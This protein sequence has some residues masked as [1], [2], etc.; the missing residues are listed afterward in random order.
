LNPTRNEAPST[1]W[2]RRAITVPVLF[3]VALIYAVVFPAAGVLAALADAL[4]RR[5]AYLRAF[6]FLGVL[7]AAELVGVVLSAVLFVARLLPGHD[8][9]WFL[10]ANSRLQ[11]RWASSLLHAA[12]R[13]FSLR[14]E[15]SG[16]D[17][18]VPGPVVMLCRHASLG[19]T[20]IPATFVTA[21]H[22]LRLRYVLKRELLYDPCLDIV[23]QRLPNAFVAR[24][25]GD[26]QREIEKVRALA[27]D[28][29]EGEGILIY[30]EG[31]RFSETR[32][33]RVIAR[34]EERGDAEGAARARALTHVL[35]PELGGTLAVL[36]GL[37][38]ADVVVCAHTGFE[39]IRTLRELTDGSLVGRAVRVRFW[40]VRRGELPSDEA[41]LVEWLHATWREVD[42]WVAA[43]AEDAGGGAPA[44]P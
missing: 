14:V 41:G 42:A 13:L 20:V 44:G 6:C 31:T 38:E 7:L 16:D 36:T 12:A 33:Q 4:A 34:L 40:R 32:R 10:D 35:P 11:G 8:D 9:A 1:T 18:T 5:T 39:G 21:R 29:G 24:G 2:G 25:S 19:D 28:V 30:P 3:V 43:H 37:P 26:P 22:R 27:H 15:V 23:G 17:V